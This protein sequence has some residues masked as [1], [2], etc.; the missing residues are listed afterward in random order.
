MPNRIN[1]GPEI[2]DPDALRVEYTRS[3]REN[4][5]RFVSGRNNQGTR[6]FSLRILLLDILL[7]C[8]IGGVIYPFIVGSNKTGKLDGISCDLSLRSDDETLYISLTMENPADGTV[9]EAVEVEFFINGQSV[10]KISDLTPNPGE[11]RTIRFKMKRD[12]EKIGVNVI[13]NK[14]EES[15]K[16]NAAAAAI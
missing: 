11:Y 14:G 2:Y 12:G 3:E 7:L 4:M 10:E 9:P 8:I 6:K 16:L 1:K 5:T 15:L 13:M